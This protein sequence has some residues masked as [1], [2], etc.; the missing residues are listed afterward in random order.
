MTHNTEDKTPEQEILDGAP[1][2][3]RFDY[4]IR[5]NATACEDEL[6]LDFDVK[7]CLCHWKDV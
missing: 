2:I 7:G 3:P 5:Y 4:T 6:L 1:V